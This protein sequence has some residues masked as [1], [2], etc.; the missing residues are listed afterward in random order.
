MKTPTQFAAQAVLEII[1]LIMHSLRASLRQPAGLPNPVHFPL[2][3]TLLEGPHSLGGLAEKLNVTPPTMSNSITTLV[4]HGLVERTPAQD[5]RRRVVIRLTPAGREL[6]ARIQAQAEDQISEL[7][8]PLSPAELEQV[9]AGLAVLKRTFGR[10]IR[11][12]E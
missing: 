8:A 5:D 12:G 6:L 3:F 7:L 9:V 4:E 2:L 11:E 1:P 10:N